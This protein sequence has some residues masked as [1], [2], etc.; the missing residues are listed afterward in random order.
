MV[1]KFAKAVKDTEQKSEC[2]GNSIVPIAI[3]AR[4]YEVSR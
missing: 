2:Y 4:V 3:C 1:L